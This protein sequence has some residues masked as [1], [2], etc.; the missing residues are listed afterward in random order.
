[1]PGSSLIKPDNSQRCHSRASKLI[2][3][4]PLPQQVKIE[5][6][7][8]TKLLEDLLMSLYCESGNVKSAGITQIYDVIAIAFGDLCLTVSFSQQACLLDQCTCSI[9]K[10]IFEDRTQVAQS[11]LGVFAILLMLV[12]QGH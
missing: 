8:D 4:G 5:C 10:W 12:N 1:M 9:C 2:L 7:V 6:Q 3:C 11:R